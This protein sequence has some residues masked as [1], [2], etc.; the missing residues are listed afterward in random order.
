MW[1]SFF[2]EFF[3][4][5]HFIGIKFSSPYRPSLMSIPVCVCTYMNMHVQYMY[6]YLCIRMS[7]EHT[8]NVTPF[9]CLP[10]WI[11]NDACFHSAMQNNNSFKHWC[12]FWWLCFGSMYTVGVWKAGAEQS[13]FAIRWL[14]LL[15]CG[16]G[17][18]QLCVSLIQ[19]HY[20][21]GLWSMSFFFGAI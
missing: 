4:N 11:S 5:V 21:W 15:W 7:K 6:A 13:S 3:K 14:V 8:D 1:T 12:W 17:D 18:M 16:L 20:L 10:W 2:S 9:S 19:S